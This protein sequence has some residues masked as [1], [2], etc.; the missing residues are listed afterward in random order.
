MQLDI[1]GIA[2]NSF[3]VENGEVRYPLVETMISCNFQELLK[4][5]VA[6]SSVAVDYGGSRYPHIAADG[7]TILTG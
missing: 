1:S 3:Y 6:I 4:N 2:K 5:I 7:V